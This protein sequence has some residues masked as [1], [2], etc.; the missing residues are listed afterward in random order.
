[1]NTIYK[2]ELE[3]TS[4]QKKLIPNGFRILHT[5]EQDGV[6]C[7]WAMVDNSIPMEAVS[8]EIYGTGHD[9]P[10][11]ANRRYVGTVLMQS[12]GLVWHVFVMQ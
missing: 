3:Q 4:K 8:F 11:N 2:F 12:T 7:I 1:M 10:E 6:I 5:A 9:I